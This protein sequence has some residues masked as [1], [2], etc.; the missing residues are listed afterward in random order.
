MSELPELKGTY[1]RLYVGFDRFFEGMDR[2]SI[3]CEGVRLTQGTVG[4]V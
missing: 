1:T 3:P 2:F 4:M